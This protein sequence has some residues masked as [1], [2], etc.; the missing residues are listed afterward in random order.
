M[1]FN[2]SFGDQDMMFVNQLAPIPGLDVISFDQ[3]SFLQPV[4]DE[5][6]LS[7]T[8]MTSTPGVEFIDGPAGNV[9]VSMEDGASCG[10]EEQ[11]C[12]GMVGQNP[13]H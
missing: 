11:V 5:V 2:H 13:L 4:P 8:S 3:A 6:G 10:Q 1:S 9:D 12:Y 7:G